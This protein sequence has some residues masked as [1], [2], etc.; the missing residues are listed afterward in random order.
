MKTFDVAV[1]GGGAAGMVAAIEAARAGSSVA[2]FDREPKLGRKL[3]VSGGGR[4]NI[5]NVVCGESAYHSI[6]AAFFTSLF[7]L[8]GKDRILSFFRE[9]G[10]PIVAESDGRMFPKVGQASSVVRVLENELSRLGVATHLSHDVSA[11]KKRGG[12]FEIS[13]GKISAKAK[14]V[15]L[16]AGGKSYPALGANGSGYAL[17]ESLGHSIVAPVPSGVP[18]VVKDQFVHLLQGQRIEVRLTAFVGG[19]PVVAAQGDVLFTNYGLS[20]TAA[21]DVSEPL[22]VA[23]HRDNNGDVHLLLDLFPDMSHEEL[24]AEFARRKKGGVQPKDMIIG[25]LPN[26]FEAVFSAMFEAVLPEEAARQLKN[27]ELAVSDTRG[28]NEAEFTSGGVPTCEV[29]AATMES[30]KTPGLYVVGETLDIRAARGGHHLAF[31][32][33]SGHIAG[34]SAAKK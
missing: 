13:A 25:L 5:M 2:L 17:A 23:L 32:W 7:S 14:R 6:N 19:D 11:V 15:V 4:C 26:K 12:E 33:A 28:W 20:G 1:V 10:L 16:A 8:F 18:L 31:C 29:D 27:V 9:L 3:G 24:A 21:I 22:S 34:V 30:K